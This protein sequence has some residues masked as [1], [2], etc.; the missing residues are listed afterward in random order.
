[1]HFIVRLALAVCSIAVLSH[2]NAALPEEATRQA[3]A[4]LELAIG[5]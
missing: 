4:L 5:K 3:Q 2:A 1:M